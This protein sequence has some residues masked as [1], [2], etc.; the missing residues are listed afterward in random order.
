MSKKK[1]VKRISQM[2]EWRQAVA[3][4]GYK[5]VQVML[6]K[7]DIDV[8]DEIKYKERLRSRGEAIKRLIDRYRTEHAVEPERLKRNE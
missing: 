4:A 3:K 8:L 5:P 6:H 2:T 7:Q 1:G